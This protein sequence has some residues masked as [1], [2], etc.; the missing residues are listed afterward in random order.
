METGRKPVKRYKLVLYSSHYRDRETYVDE[1]GNSKFALTEIDAKTTDYD[2][3]S[4]FITA[5][6]LNPACDRLEIVYQAKQQTRHLIAVFS[7]DEFLKKLSHDNIGKYQVNPNYYFTS[8]A[9]RICLKIINNDDLLKYLIRY[10]YISGTPLIN[11]FESLICGYHGYRSEYEYSLKILLN[12]L[13]HYKVIRGLVVG[14]NNYKIV[15]ETDD[16]ETILSKPMS[17]SPQ[18]VLIKN[19]QDLKKENYSQDSLFS[20]NYSQGTLFDDELNVK[21][22]KYH[23]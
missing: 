20:N 19:T 1:Q 15:H 4:Q 14:I 6:R 22:K 13:Q 11:Y 9:E 23:K 8:Q 17:K 5:N 16:K 18:N 2:D 3:V 10:N 12:R 21:T 7:K